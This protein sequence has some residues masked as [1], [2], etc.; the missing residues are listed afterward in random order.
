ML[1][2]LLQVGYRDDREIIGTFQTREKAAAALMEWCHENY[3]PVYYTRHWEENGEE[4]IDY[5]SWGTFGY[6]T[7]LGN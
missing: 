3:G 4:I 1:Q 5:G 6:I 2:Y 7:K